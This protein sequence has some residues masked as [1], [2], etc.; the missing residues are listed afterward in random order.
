M[1]DEVEKA[2][3]GNRRKDC[4]FLVVQGPFG[5]RLTVDLVYPGVSECCDG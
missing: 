1:M 4:G 5:T 3:Q 2:G